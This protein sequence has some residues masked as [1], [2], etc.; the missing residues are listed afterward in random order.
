MEVETIDAPVA[1]NARNAIA[2]ATPG[3]NENEALHQE[4]E[5]DLERGNELNVGALKATSGNVTK[6]LGTR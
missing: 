4:I 6:R 5:A 3:N 2:V 1:Y